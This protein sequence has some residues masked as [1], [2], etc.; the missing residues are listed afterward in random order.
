M[1]RKPFLIGLAY[2]MTLFAITPIAHAQA[3]IR[4]PWL[5][6]IAPTEPGRGGAHSTDIDSLAVASGGTVTEADIAANGANEGDTVGN[7]VWT[8]GEISPNTGDI[9]AVIN[10]IGMAAGELDNHTSYA[11]VALESA[12]PQRGVTMR[13][14]SDDSIKVWL[15]GEVVHRKAV[16]RSSAGFQDE[17]QVD[18]LAGDNLLMVKVS[19][20]WGDWK[21]FVGIDGGVKVGGDQGTV[22]T[23]D[24]THGDVGQQ[25]V[26]IPDPNL[27]AAVESA[28]GVAAGTSIAVDEMATLIRLEANEAGISNLTGLEGATNLTTLTLW[29]NSITDLSPLAGLTNLTTLMLGINNISDISALAGLINLTLL[30]LQYNNINDISPLVANAG[31]GG[32]DTIYVNGNHLLSINH[33]SIK[34][35]IPTLQSRGVT[36]EFDDRTHLNVGEPYTVRLIYFLP[37]DRQPQPDIDAKM[38]TLIKEVQQFYANQMENH[39]FGRKTFQ[40]ET[41]VTGKAVVHHVNGKFNDAHYQHPSWIVWEEIDQQFDMS[42]AFYL[43]ALD[44]SSELIDNRVCGKGGFSGFA[45]IPAIGGGAA[46]IPASGRCFNVTVTAHELGHAFGLQH[47]N[48]RGEN[49][50]WISSS[51]V[52]DPMTTSFC[53]A[54]WLD[55]H[56]AFNTTSFSRSII[57]AKVEMLPPSLVSPP[58][59]IRLRFEVTDPDGLHQ[60]Q[61]H[62]P[63]VE[64]YVLG[65]FLACKGL[66]DISSGIEFV[67]TELVPRNKSVSLVVMDVHGNFSSSQ[68]FPIDVTS[69][70]PPPETVSI[71]D[72]NL[73]AAVGHEI[74]L[75]ITTHTMLNLTSLD[76]PNRQ[77]TDLT[78]LE[79]AR[80]LNRLDLD[81]NE[82]LNLSPLSGLT[83]LVRLNLSGNSISDVSALSGLTRLEILDLSDNSISD[84]SA[85][86]GLTQLGWLYLS[87]NSISDVSALSGLTQLTYLWLH[88][89]SISDVSPLLELNLTGTQGD[90]TGLYLWVNPL[91]YA[92][93]HTH[94]PAM[95]A[96]GIEVEF[97][98]RSHPTLL[99][100]SGDNQTGT[101]FAPLSQPFVVEVQDAKGA[102]SAGISVTFAVVTGGGTLSTT[103]T[104]TDGNGR[105]ESTLT[106]GPNLGINT[107]EVSAT[108]IQGSVI[109]H[110]TS[111]YLPTEHLWSIPRGVSLIHVPLKVTAVD[112]VAKTITSVADLYDA[113]GGADTVNFLITYDS[114]TQGW[115]IYFGAADKDTPTDKTLI[116]DTGIIAGMKAS[117]SLRLRGNALGIN[118]NSAITLHPGIN[119]VGVPLRDLRITR[120]S[121]LF[122]LEGIGGNVSTI[123]VLDSGGFRTIKQRGDASDIAITGGQSLILTVQEAATVA[124]SGGAWYN[125]S[126][127]ATTDLPRTITGIEVGD[128]TPV[129]ALSGSIVDQGTGVNKAGFRV[130]AKNLSTARAAT[131]IIGDENHLSPETWESKEVEYQFTIV[132]TKAGRAAKIGDILEISVQSPESSIGAEPLQYTVTAEDVLRGRIELGGLAIYGILWETGLLQNYPNPFTPETWIP[133]RLAEDAFVTVIIYD[134]TGQIVRT[135]KVGHRIAEVYESRSKAVYWDGR[136][137]LGERVASGVYFYTLTA[138]D[139]FATRK[140]VILK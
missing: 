39:G 54:E 16:D 53:A 62:T 56:R 66:T 3:K 136:N 36:V 87:D 126:E 30:M 70:L 12:S 100:I 125:I 111:D 81:S 137:E 91:S 68:K 104:T 84:V 113:L 35:H 59:V 28:L 98:N 89:N 130:T 106:L 67:T 41:D 22:P 97:D 23:D 114:P 135:L 1:Y 115:F 44:V 72:A 80:N 75:P 99:K 108:G 129:L 103:N 117:V 42:N 128:T 51:G 107:V 48:R 119:L 73:A 25:M 118:G 85:L 96:R 133:Y 94:I 40:F 110:A 76:I 71:P 33:T 18:L 7:Y 21:M 74:G 140:M 90:S 55:A 52:I 49:G 139:Y 102:V 13:V 65:G 132:D 105:A 34:T 122:A 14:G 38:D 93:I 5:W 101:A 69:L 95:Q 57:K 11:L 19:E 63:E 61:L 127:M 10:Q 4:G 79:H 77:I 45:R 116:D 47:D 27:R 109:F 138:G 86:S 78:G 32:G 24:S 124:I 8:F 82:V 20:L 83:R 6:M 37:N 64:P 134:Q 43:T 131:T 2:L 50:K 92:S 121:D 112:G 15:N 9:N 120:V 29:S 26:N 31:L 88:N 123:T 46:L 17:F 60:A 58:N